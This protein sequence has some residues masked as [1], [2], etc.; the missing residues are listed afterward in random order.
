[1]QS[2]QCNMCRRILGIRCSERGNINQKG[3]DKS[4]LPFDLYG[5]QINDNYLPRNY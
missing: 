1:M 2:Y 4:H 3:D 5:W